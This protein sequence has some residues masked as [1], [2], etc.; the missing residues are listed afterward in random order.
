M[1]AASANAYLRTRVLTAN[2]AE[3]RLMLLD[4]AIRF[5]EQARD[6]LA[7]KDFEAVYNGA[8][9]CQNILL[10]LISGLRPEHDEAL[11]EKLSSLYTFMYLHM[12]KA[13]SERKADM[14]DEVL[15]L[16]RFERETW[17]LVLE[18]IARGERGT[19]DSAAASPQPTAPPNVSPLPGATISMRG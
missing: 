5:A 3:L 6:G 18:K 7:R 14:F 19:H 4:G 15:K 11:C 10:E 12:V 2:P 1:P 17:Q 8:T 16:L 9:R 13:A